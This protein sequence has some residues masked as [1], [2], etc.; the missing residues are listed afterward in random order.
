M[1]SSAGGARNTPGRLLKTAIAL[2]HW[3]QVEELQA[4]RGHNSVI[5]HPI[6]GWCSEPQPVFSCFSSLAVR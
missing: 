4:I 5:V 2:L 6:Q 1:L 3:T